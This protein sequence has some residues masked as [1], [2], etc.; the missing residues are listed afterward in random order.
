MTANADHGAAGRGRRRDMTVMHRRPGA[1]AILVAVAAMALAACSGGGSSGPQV[2]SL[3]TS[4]GPG[5][6]TGSGTS[7]D[8]GASSGASSGVGGGSG[9]R[10]TIAGNVN[11]L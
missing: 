7:A 4:S 11:P 6:G 3:G 5:S 9:T 8:P 1:L 10:A 2:A